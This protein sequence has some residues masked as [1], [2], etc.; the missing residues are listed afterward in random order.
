MKNLDYNKVMCVIGILFIIIFCIVLIIEYNTY[1]I[2][3]SAPFSVIVLVRAIEFWL[4]GAILIYLYN[5]NTNL[6]ETR[7]LI[8]S[9][10]LPKSFSGYKIAHISD[11][12]NTNSRKV[13]RKILETLENNRPDIIVITG[14]LVDSRRTNIPNAKEFLKNVVK[15]SPVYYVLGNNESRLCDVQS[16]IDEVQSVG[17]NVQRNINSKIEKQGEAIEL[18]GL[19]DPAFFIP[20]ESKDEIRKKTDDVLKSIVRDSD[21][22]K[23][24]LIH[25]PELLDVYAKYNFDLIFTGHAHGGQIRLPLIGGIIAP[26]QGIFPKYTK[27][28]YNVGNTQMV[29]SRGIGNSKFPF[30]INN[31]PEIIFVTLE[32]NKSN[33]NENTI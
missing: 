28:I 22:F 19:D 30:R 15:I 13:K 9:D 18:L 16:L 27:G 31:R 2:F 3:N 17:V 1:D 10:K 6:K 33:T 14:D 8:Q 4:P 25:R 5:Q 21:N 20:L 26:G 32:K 11:L 7:Y 23:L 29:V 12:H 24:L